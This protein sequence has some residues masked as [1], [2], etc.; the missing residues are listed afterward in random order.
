VKAGDDA[1]DHFGGVGV[2]LRRVV[3]DDPG[4]EQAV[5]RISRRVKNGTLFK[6]DAGCVTGKMF[7]S[8]QV[9]VLD[10]GFSRQ[11]T[12][13]THRYLPLAASMTPQVK[14]YVCSGDTGTYFSG[15]RLDDISAEIK[16]K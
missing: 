12:Q 9:M 7:S 4:R 14:E 3:Q 13:V 8:P 2:V 5:D 10:T 6:H 1:L 11:P 16:I 15:D